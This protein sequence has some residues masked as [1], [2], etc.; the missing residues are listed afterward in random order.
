MP[1][2][3]DHAGTAS[4]LSH[5]P[6]AAESSSSLQPTPMFLRPPTQPAS[7]LSSPPSAPNGPLDG[8]ENAVE[9]RKLIV[10]PGVTVSGDIGSCDAIVIEGNVRANMQGCQHMAITATGLF[11]GNAVINE[12]EVHG[13]FEGDLTV[14]SRLWVR[15]TGQVSGSI[16]YGQIEIEAGGMISGSVRS[17]RS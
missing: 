15:A 1:D 2:Q 10:G 3:L 13:R 12:A 6:T 14:R 4:K 7:A 9:P 11:D 8:R 17:T 5:P 16:N